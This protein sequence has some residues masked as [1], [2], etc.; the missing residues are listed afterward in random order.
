MEQNS[1]KKI[2]F[3]F[4]ILNKITLIYWMALI[5]IY[6]YIYIWFIYDLYIYIR[7]VGRVIANDPEDSKNG[8]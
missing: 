6:I 3:T 2:K 1:E 5:Y 8:S 4:S 7:L